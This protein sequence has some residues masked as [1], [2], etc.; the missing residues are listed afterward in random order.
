MDVEL[1]GGKFNLTDVNAAIGLGQLPQLDD[2]TRRRA[3]LA[4][5]YF[6]PPSVTVATACGIELP[7]PTTPTTRR[8]TGTCSRWCL[9]ADR[10]QAGAPR[11]W[12]ACARTASAPACT[13]RRAPVHA[14]PRAGL[15]RRHA[16]RTPSASAAASLTLPLFPAMHDADVERVCASLAERMRRPCCVSARDL[17]VVI[18]VYNEEAVLP[19]LF[20]RL[21]RALDALRRALRDHLRERR[22]PRPL[23]G[24]AARAVPRRAPT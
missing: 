3:E 1:P 19:A 12:S 2:V 17:S 15:A 24:D 7:P 20:E 21:Y 6:E 10:L 13:T 18:P 23:G 22:Q 5:R 14:L 11:S 9:P 4:R 16:A 8:P